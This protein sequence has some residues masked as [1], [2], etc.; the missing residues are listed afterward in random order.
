MLHNP[1][2]LSHPLTLSQNLTFTCVILENEVGI[3]RWNIK[4][5]THTPVNT[6]RICCAYMKPPCEA[7]TEILNPHLRLNQITEIKMLKG[8]P[9]CGSPVF[10]P[11]R[12]PWPDDALTRFKKIPVKLMYDSLWYVMLHDNAPLIHLMASISVPLRKSSRN[13]L[14]LFFEMLS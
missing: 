10:V 3:I 12:A 7:S 14:D 2:A 13:L 9:S 8:F 6:L 11:P 1:L 4:I 5:Q